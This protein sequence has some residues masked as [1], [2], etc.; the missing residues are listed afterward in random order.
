MRTNKVRGHKRL[1]R[2][3][4][5]WVENN[6]TL[7]LESLKSNMYDY[8]KIWIYPW[9]GINMSFSNTPEPNSKTK[10]KMLLGLH[11]IYKRWNEQLLTLNE[12]FYL[13]IW[14]FE[15]RIS[16]SQVVCAI[17]DRIE[18]YNGIFEKQS[19]EKSHIPKYLVDK[20][21]W[22][23]HVDYEFFQKSDLLWPEDQYSTEDGYLWD[24]RLLRKL[25]NGN[26]RSEIIELG[27][28]KDIMFYVPKGRIWTGK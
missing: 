18:Y 9:S 13:K 28:E 4:D 21:E 8:T 7:N 3:I 23:S 11:K 12:P 6:S 22:E 25:E 16:K 24:R 17:G 19:Y 15:P 1:W 5:K 2:E 20:F 10:E 26:F 27:E 14:F